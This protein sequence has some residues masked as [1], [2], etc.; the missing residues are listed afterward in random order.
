MSEILHCKA[1]IMVLG[2]NKHSVKKKKM[3]AAVWTLLFYL[4]INQHSLSSMAVSVLSLRE[5][6]K[7]RGQDICCNFQSSWG[8][9]SGKWGRGN[10]HAWQE[11]KE[12]IR[13][14]DDK[15]CWVLEVLRAGF[16]MKQRQDLSRL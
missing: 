9:Q 14:S 7:R 12:G 4:S 6:H 16:K 13:R 3:I 1:L 15:H 10:D 2:D 8:N 5:R 11:S